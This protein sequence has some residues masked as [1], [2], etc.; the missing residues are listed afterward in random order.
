MINEKDFENIQSSPSSTM[1]HIIETIEN[2]SEINIDNPTNPFV[3]NLETSVAGTRFALDELASNMRILFPSLAVEESDLFHHIT[4]DEESGTFA[5]PSDVKLTFMISVNKI[6]EVGIYNEDTETFKVTLPK[7]TEVIVADTTFT[8]LHDIDIF[9]RGNYSYV[10]EIID[11]NS[12]DN[13]GNVY[14]VITKDVDNLDWITFDIRIKQIKREYV[15]I[16]LIAG[17]KV[18]LT[19]DLEDQYAY[20]KAY[21]VTPTGTTTVNI[22]HNSSV[23]DHDKLTLRVKVSESKVNYTIPMFYLI[24]GITNTNLLIEI[25]TT[26][27]R[28]VIPLNKFNT[29]DFNIKLPNKFFTPEAAVMEKIDKLALSRNIVDGGSNIK[30]FEE[31]RKEVIFNTTGVRDLPITEHSLTQHVNNRNFQITKVEDNL[32]LRSYIVSKDINSEYK[33]LNIKS[34]IDIL[35]GELE[36]YKPD[37]D[38]KS[39]T[40]KN[41]DILIKSNTLI[42]VINGKFKPLSDLEVNYVRT[43]NLTDLTEFMKNTEVYNIPF[44]YLL[45]EDRDILETY[46]YDLDKP[47]IK[48]LYIMNKNTYLI[49]NVNITRYGV[50]KT[51]SGFD[52]HFTLYGNKEF[53]KIQK[54]EVY[55]QL[56]FPLGD[57]KV[58]FK[59]KF[60]V[61]TNTYK[62][63]I[64]SD[65][66]LTDSK[67]LNVTNGFSQLYDK[68][69]NLNENVEL[70]IYTTV[71]T[72]H[73]DNRYKP[74]LEVVNES[75]ANAF[76]KESVNIILGNVLN[77]LWNKSYMTYTDLR[78][79]RASEDEYLTYKD[80]VY[81]GDIVNDDGVVIHSNDKSYFSTKLL[82]R[83]GDIVR[84]DLGKPLFKH[85]K[86]EYLRDENND[87][88][89]DTISGKAYF[90]DV[91]VTQ[92]E[93]IVTG[94][95]LYKNYYDTVIDIIRNWL[96]D[97]LKVFNEKLLEHSFIYYRPHKKIVP[98]KINGNLYTDNLIRPTVTLY[99]D[100]NLFSVVSQD[101]E[102]SIIGKI[103]H[104]H[105][106]RNIFSLTDIREEIK[107]TLSA[108]LISVKIEGITENNTELIEYTDRT[109]RIILDKII[110]TNKEV[111]Y[112]INLK[113]ETL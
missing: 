59:A 90:I 45:R 53:E 49:E 37:V 43:S 54:D 38:Q 41:N 65:F 42:K 64:E 75:N 88:I 66:F 95:K 35:H 5:I 57:T 106:S 15:E 108:G 91:L 81:S 6:K 12:T 20:T 103:I 84:D 14:S 34:N 105:I 102:I 97:D 21:L 98:P 94:N 99:I 29:N 76:T 31:L 17:Q 87:L 11:T 10:E 71:E 58:Y 51:D 13:T 30:T 93:Y 89:E 44:Y 110:T 83:K 60:N 9:Y 79:M 52:L 69:I 113:I 48:N 61:D 80:N 22:T 63:T 55:I 33:D 36:L 82:Y 27:G 19:I 26:K 74:T 4:T 56:A 23:Y 39:I 8:I 25:Y 1:R 72:I 68:N 77:T 67:R 85:R 40:Y 96:N 18:D 100:Q 73:V 32:T 92:A 111:N 47:D 46:I 109:N 28:I 24:D 7:F 107:T 62:A 70:I 86:G 112:D 104:K 3:L 101:N 50:F 78:F 16:G 2:N